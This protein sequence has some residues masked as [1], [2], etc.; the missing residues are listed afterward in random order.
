MRYLRPPSASPAAPRPPPGHSVASAKRRRWCRG[1][2]PSPPRTVPGA[3]AVCRPGRAASRQRGIPRRSEPGRQDPGLEGLGSIT[4]PPLTGNWGGLP[5][6]V[7]ARAGPGRN[8]RRLTGV[9]LAV[10]LW[11]ASVPHPG[12]TGPHVARFSRPRRARHD[13]LRPSFNSRR[14]HRPAGR[15]R[16]RPLGHPP[17]SRRRHHGAHRRLCPGRG[18]GLPA[19]PVF[20]ADGVRDQGGRSPGAGE[21]RGAG[22]PPTAIRWSA[23]PSSSAR[24]ARR[25]R[26]SS[27]CAWPPRP[28]CA[29]PRRPAPD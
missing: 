15:L 13:V 9:R 8:Q 25:S 14:H 26:A 27:A 16:A 7:N 17:G 11:L 19:P 28:T 20:R 1:W 21:L 29:P 24:P 12:R 2:A 6:R 10:R 4:L 23:S 3:E 5:W 18:D 22:M